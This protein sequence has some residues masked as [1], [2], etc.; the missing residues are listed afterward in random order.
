MRNITGQAVI[1]DDLYGREYELTR[2]WERLEQGE[3]LLM[4]A[5]RRVGKTSLMLELRRAPRENW[6]VVYVDVEGGDGPADCVAAILAAL[7]ASPKYRSRFEAIPL[8]RAIGDVLGRLS[9]SVDTDLLRVELKSAIGREWAHAADQLRARLVGL[10]DASSNLLIIIDELPILVSRILRTGGQERDA[11]LLL[12]WFRQLRQAPELRDKICTLVGGSIGLEGVLRRAR[13]SGSINDLVPFRL[14]SW[15][16]PTAVEFLNALGNNYD[17]HLDDEYVA[18]LLD[19]LGDPVPYHVQLF[20]STLRD[21]CRGESVCVSPEV[22]ER[23]FEER[24]A[25]ATGSA[26]LDHY[27]TR[28]EIAFDEFEHETAR[29]ILGYVCR[30]TD[31][32]TLAELEELRRGSGQT[33]PSVLRELEADGYLVRQDER[34]RFRSNLLRAWWRKHYGRGIAA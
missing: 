3:H 21:A 8:S 23:C 13:L 10:P 33:F 17:F 34:L 16:R 2:L 26:H 12:S 30:R 11:E 9:A 18:L 24:L 32:A 6:D 25:G 27:A 4:L 28:L 5:P 29:G 20:F 7:A 1:G 22:I 19:L 31:G 15:S 14:D